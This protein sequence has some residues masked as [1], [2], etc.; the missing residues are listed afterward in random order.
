[1][2]CVENGYYSIIE[3]DA[4][5]VT[6]NGKTASVTVRMTEEKKCT[7][8]SAPE[9]PEANYAVSNIRFENNHTLG[10]FLKWDAP[11]DL[12]QS[13]Y[14]YIVEGR[15]ASSGEWEE[16]FST[17][18]T[19][20]SCSVL[21]G[22]D[23][24]SIRI[25]T[26]DIVAKKN[27]GI[28]QDDS[29]SIKVNAVI[30]EDTYHKVKLAPVEGSATGDY[31]YTIKSM[32]FDSVFY[33][34]M[35]GA[36]GELNS[37]HTGR[38]DYSGNANRTVNASNFA[39][40]VESGYYLLQYVYNVQLDENCKNVSYNLC[41]Y[42]EKAHYDPSA[43]N[44]IKGA[45]YRNDYEGYVMLEWDVADE[46]KYNGYK[47]DVY[48]SKNGG[49]D[50]RYAGSST[51]PSIELVSPFLE[52]EHYSRVKYNAVKIVG[53]IDGT[54]ETYIGD[55][56]SLEI[57][58]LS[59]ITYPTV[60]FTKGSDDAGDNYTAAIKFPGKN[61]ID[62]N[63]NYKMFLYDSNMNP[64]AS[65]GMYFNSDSVETTAYFNGEDC[66]D[67]IENGYYEIVGTKDV[68]VDTACKSA[69]YK[70]AKTPALVA[71]TPSDSLDVEIK[72]I[73]GTGDVQV[74]FEMPAEYD[75]VKLVI[76]EKGY[77]TE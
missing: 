62:Y 18:G 10:V 24:D 39:E 6:N 37:T 72:V 66:I 64:V 60:T 34:K 21:E 3:H 17:T 8:T 46:Y 67:A 56:I 73:E 16:M 27:V 77:S 5:T 41:S 53:E 36:D 63:L 42:G 59:T 69:S 28:M 4:A 70:M 29:M 45:S 65:R 20:S 61:Y 31:E 32:A 47:Y 2:N 43:L 19:D 40:D 49:T 25:T 9:V 15:D 44:I 14:L 76:T 55:D 13:T 33:L 7:D 50:W 12:P 71:C 68:T 52:Y 23:Y 30:D 26:Y 75:S 74:N 51:Y 54:M 22:C 57:I 48:L 1:D 35:Y 11:A 58:P 38:S